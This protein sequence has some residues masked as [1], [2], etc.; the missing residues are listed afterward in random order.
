MFRMPR[1]L[2][3]SPKLLSSSDIIDQSCRISEVFGK[4]NYIVIIFLIDTQTFLQVYNTVSIYIFLLFIVHNPHQT[5]PLFLLSKLPL[6]VF[7]L[8]N[9]L[10]DDISALS[11]LM[12]YCGYSVLFS[13]LLYLSYPNPEKLAKSAVKE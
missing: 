7:W 4:N 11:P 13:H 9:L 6:K 8:V 10:P 2:S 3:W 1:L 12:N 5:V